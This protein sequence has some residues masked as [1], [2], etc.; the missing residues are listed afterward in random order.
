MKIAIFYMTKFPQSLEKGR[1]IIQN[2]R[3]IQ[4][5]KG[6]TFYQ[7]DNRNLHLFLNIY[8][9]SPVMRVWA[10]MFINK[11]LYEVWIIVVL[12]LQSQNKSL[13]PLVAFIGYSVPALMLISL[14]PSACHHHLISTV[15]LPLNLSFVHTALSLGSKCFFSRPPLFSLLLFC[16]LRKCLTIVA[17]TDLKNHYEVLASLE[18][19]TLLPLLPES[20][21]NRHVTTRLVPIWLFKCP[22][23]ILQTLSVSQMPF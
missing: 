22:F 6:P 13:I 1:M 18:L 4:A 14:A 15:K 5:C 19:T 17:L 12:L 11:T 20:W 21:A 16:F 10:L 7:N 23:V 2:K 8:C 3:L 9:Q